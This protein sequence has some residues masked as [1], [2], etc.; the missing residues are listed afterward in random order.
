VERR[1]FVSVTA[2][3]TLDERRRT[4][5][6]AILDRIKQAG[7]APQEFWESGIAENLAWNFE[8][9]QE[10]M[11]RCVGAVVIGFPRWTVSDGSV[12]RRIVGDFNQYEGA[13][14]ITL[15]LPVMLIAEQDVEGRAIV[16]NGAGKT[17]TDLPNDAGPDWVTSEEFEKRFAAWKRELEFRRDVFLGYCSK[18][19]GLAFEI[20]ERLQGLGATVLNYAMDFRAG[21]SILNELEEASARCS[22][23]VF[24]FTEDDPLDGGEG[25]A[26]PRDNVVFEAGHFMATKGATR[27]LIIREGAA[28]M[29]A[30]VGG[31]IYVPLAKGGD[32]E[33]IEGRLR[34]FLESNL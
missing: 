17:I 9:V 4:V 18:S 8:N 10:V 23:G 11:S 34:R 22:S 27:C 3:R 16:W 30:D 14:A 31:A 7:Y 20:Q 24:L 32:A 29:P 25:I 28:K 13:V 15:G 21:S 5:K 6:A 19:K 1:V 33:A 12:K 26:A 2:T